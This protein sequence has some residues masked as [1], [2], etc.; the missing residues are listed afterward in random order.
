MG[1]PVAQPPKLFRVLA[2]VDSLDKSMEFYD[3]LLGI[4]GRRVGGGRA[5][6]DCGPVTVG[7]VDVATAG[8]KPV[9]APQHLYF[10]VPD[11]EETFARAKVL[12]C[13]SPEDVH[14][15]PAGE[16]R[17][18]PWGERCFYAVDPFG[19][20]LCFSDENTLFMGR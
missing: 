16:I 9:A 11:L 20:G 17:T 6:Y 18:R 7:L 19:N 13:L 15:E 10:A 2:E 12:G 4:A 14:G 8:K 5:Y 1:G 3:R